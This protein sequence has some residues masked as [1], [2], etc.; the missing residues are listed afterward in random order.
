[1][2]IK[3]NKQSAE[4]DKKEEFS[5]KDLHFSFDLSNTNYEIDTLQNRLL[6]LYLRA[7]PRFRKAF[8]T[9]YTQD[10]LQFLKDKSRLREPVHLSVIGQTRGGKSY[11]TISVA[12]FIMACYGKRFTIKYICANAYEFLEKLKVMSEEELINSCFL[13]D[14]EKQSVFGVGSMAK[15]MKLTDV[16]NIIAMNNISTIMLNP[17]TW[18]NKE[19]MYG[20]R[21]FGKDRNSKTCRMMLYN[22]QERGKGGELPLGNVYLPIFTA[23]LPKE[24]AEQLEKEYLAKKKNWIR[25]E[26]RGEGDV[27]AEL[28]KKSALNFCKDANFLKIKS[29]KEKAGYIQQKM[30][31]E[32]TSKECEDILVLTSLIQQ[33][34]L[35]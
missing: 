24:Y 6:Q 34:I 15:K 22:L 19:A 29:K 13:I 30:G 8:S 14:E 26:M 33:G 5:L 23:F 2:E 9:N 27:L 20:L 11:T 7:D 3:D 35:E 12:T 1:M 10:F 21:L 18:A 16:Q 32:W 25:G 31:S 28:R 17:I 4:N